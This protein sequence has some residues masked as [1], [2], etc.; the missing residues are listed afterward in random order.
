[1]IAVHLSRHSLSGSP[2]TEAGPAV[3]PLWV[4]RLRGSQAEMGHQHGVLLRRAGGWRP[5]ADFYPGMP[6]RMLLGHI[7]D[8]GLASLAR[9]LARGVRDRLLDRL[10]AAR[11]PA[12]RERSRAFAV[13]LGLPAD[14]SRYISV[15]DLFQNAVNTAGRFRAGPFG[16]PFTAA[17]VHAARPACST[18]M[19]WD[20]ASAGGG[21]RHARNFDFPGAGIWDLAPAVV[22]CS[23]DEGQR[24]AFVTTRGADIPG[25]TAFNEAGLVVTAHTRFHRDVRLDGAGIV[26]I[27][28]DIVR[29]CETIADAVKVAGERRSASTWGLA[30]SSGREGKAVVIEL[31]GGGAAVVEPS[32]GA[33]ALTC[34]NRYRH[35][36]MIGGQIAA[37]P[38]WAAHSDTR[39]RRLGE[40]VARGRARG[41]LDAGDLMAAL[42]DRIDP[43]DPAGIERGAGGTIAQACTVQ[44]VVVEPTERRLRLAVGPAPAAAGPWLAIDW[45]WEGDAAAPAQEIAL[46]PSPPRD[47]AGRAY[48]SWVESIRAE[49]ADHDPRAAL[50]ALERAVILAPDDPSYRLLAGWLRLRAGD[51]G[52]ARLHLEHGLGRE[53]APFRRAQL[54]LWAA[55]AADLTGDAGRARALRGQLEVLAEATVD[56]ADGVRA[57]AAQARADA[58][59]PY[60]AERARRIAI[61]PMM[62]DA[63]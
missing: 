36:S 47:P 12:Y 28:H 41:G 8:G 51:A 35:P 52:A 26:D 61:N 59:K 5:A 46:P 18:V 38:A 58:A 48:A 4:A 56:G 20:G 49:V 60:T 9:F 33:D 40:L 29:R 39:Q 13:A 25:V 62:C 44:S 10:E 2:S 23:P 32:D 42:D 63:V 30:V 34:A 45:D 1:M 21:L 14:H 15:M 55:R 22:F 24:Y 7:G 54:L 50:A 53:E 3:Q 27:G 6:D 31:S 11:P 19:V 43:T 16:A 17:A 37:S 57:L